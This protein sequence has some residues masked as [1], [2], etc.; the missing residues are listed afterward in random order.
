MFAYHSPSILNAILGL[1]LLF[2]SWIFECVF[3]QRM[4]KFY[5]LFKGC[6]EN[7]YGWTVPDGKRET[8]EGN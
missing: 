1:L 8:T 2:C 7:E 5:C 3:L 6:N 4:T